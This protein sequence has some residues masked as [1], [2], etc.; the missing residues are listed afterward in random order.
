MQRLECEIERHHLRQRCR[1]ENH[2]GIFGLKDLAGSCID[3]NMRVAGCANFCRCGCQRCQN[4]E[5]G[6]NRQA[7]DAFHHEGEVSIIEDDPG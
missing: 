6:E 3:Q 7:E 2:I 5:K 1:I 4:A